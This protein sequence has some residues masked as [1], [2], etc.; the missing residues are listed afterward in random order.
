[1]AENE[2]THLCPR[3]C[4]QGGQE[5]VHAAD[6]LAQAQPHV[7]REQKQRSCPTCFAKSRPSWDCTRGRRLPSET[8]WD[9]T[10][11]DPLAPLG[12]TG[13]ANERDIVVLLPGSVLK[14]P[15]SPTQAGPVSHLHHHHIVLR[16]QLAKLVL[17]FQHSLHQGH[18]IVVHEVIGPVQI[19]CGLDGLK[20]RG[21][22]PAVHGSREDPSATIIHSWECTT[23]NQGRGLCF[24]TTA[25]CPGVEP[26]LLPLGSRSSNWGTQPKC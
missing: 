10:S 3:R 25:L 26:L 15:T 19:G 8:A 24:A 18:D 22:W 12:S 5:V 20:E 9:W 21:G 23:I 14:P 17:K 2:G 6:E 11:Q 13:L 4:W 16:G 1:M 7:L